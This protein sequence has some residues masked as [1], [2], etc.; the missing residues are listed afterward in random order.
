[1]IYLTEIAD[2][3]IRGSLGMFVQV[4]NNTGS[5]VVYSVGPFVS[6][7]SLN[8]I[9]L[10]FSVFFAIICLWIPETPYYHLVNGRLAE[11]K[12]QFM[13][14]KGTKNETVCEL[15]PNEN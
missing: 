13:I 6:Y 7:T 15:Y 12:K 3:E 1:M 4:M 9:V 10:S 11:A 14:I 5:L 2:K 8:L